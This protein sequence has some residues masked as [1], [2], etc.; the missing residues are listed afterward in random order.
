MNDRTYARS[1]CLVSWTGLVRDSKLSD[2]RNQLVLGGP[3][4]A[5]DRGG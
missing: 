1:L 4:A 3:G 5:R 2:F